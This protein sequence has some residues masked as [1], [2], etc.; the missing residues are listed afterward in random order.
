MNFL[1]K[2]LF[3]AFGTNEEKIQE[4][5]SKIP[6][7]IDILVTHSPPAMILDEDYKEQRL[8]CPHLLKEVLSRVK[9]SIHLFGHNHGNNKIVRTKQIFL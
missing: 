2:I 5:W 7:G 9:P 4:H 8:G 6:E 1:V 3:L